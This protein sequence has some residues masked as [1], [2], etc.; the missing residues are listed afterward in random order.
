M[1]LVQQFRNNR[2]FIHLGLALLLLGVLF[3]CFYTRERLPETLIPVGYADGMLVSGTTQIAVSIAD[4]TTEREQGLSGTA[5]LPTG[6]GKLFVFEQ[7]GTYGFWMKDMNYSIDIIWL[8]EYINIISIT[9]YVS[10][11]TY[12]EVFYPNSPIV[13]A[14][15]V[16]AGFSTAKGL[17]RG[18]SF[19]FQK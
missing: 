11:E 10:P 5:E 12:P 16:P 8:D 15:E 4:T 3:L 14:L 7:P 9:E 1:I 13:Y 19:T 2:F 17:K 18:Q 6:A